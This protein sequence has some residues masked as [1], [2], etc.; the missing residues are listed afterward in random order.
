M[1]KKISEKTRVSSLRYFCIPLLSP[2]AVIK[3][4]NT[5]KN[6]GS[7]DCVT[8]C[9]ESNGVFKEAVMII[10]CLFSRGTVKRDLVHYLYV[11]ELETMWP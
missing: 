4:S 3:K 11:F 8:A 9:V 2:A 5:Y 6:Q 10:S 1:Q 7:F